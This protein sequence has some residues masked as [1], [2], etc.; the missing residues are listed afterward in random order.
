MALTRRDI[1]CSQKEAI[2]PHTS[3]LSNI[4]GMISGSEGS[5]I[6]ILSIRTRRWAGL[7][8]MLGRVLVCAA[9]VAYC[10]GLSAYAAQVRTK[11]PVST[12]ASRNVSPRPRLLAQA[13][14]EWIANT[15]LFPATP[16]TEKHSRALAWRLRLT[17]VLAVLSVPAPGS[18]CTRR[19]TSAYWCATEASWRIV[20]ASYDTMR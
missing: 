19:Y 15:V 16:G 4:L 12:C 8:R 10:H 11:Q 7:E 2:A 13:R 17:M 9:V 3:S 6:P 20:A 14:Q 18:F 1:T 5:D